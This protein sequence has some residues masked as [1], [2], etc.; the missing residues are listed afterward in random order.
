M[1]TERGLSGDGGAG[2]LG[3][4]NGSGGR[5]GAI[6]LG[7]QRPGVVLAGAHAAPVGLR[8]S[9]HAV[10]LLLLVMMLLLLPSAEAGKD[11]SGARIAG[12]LGLRKGRH[13]PRSPVW[14]VCASFHQLCVAAPPDNERE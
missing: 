7:G 10:L 9:G 11:G 4:P 14:Y 1:A 3:R 13:D 6:G 12:G 2:A 8:S 5:L